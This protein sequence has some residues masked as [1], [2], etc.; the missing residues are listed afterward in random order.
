MQL[1]L[2]KQKPFTGHQLTDVFTKVEECWQKYGA[3][4]CDNQA[5]NSTITGYF[6]SR[7][8]TESF[9]YEI[10]SL[11]IALQIIQKLDII[12]GI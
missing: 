8:T 7:V 4:L 1:Y 2:S 11:M 3:T 12:S 10:P 5:H 9:M 6:S